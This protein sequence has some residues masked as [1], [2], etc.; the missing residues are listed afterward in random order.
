MKYKEIDLTVTDDHRNLKQSIYKFSMEV[1]R[2]A[3]IELD[4]MTPGQVISKGSPFWQGMEKMYEHS[5]HA[6]VLPE[7]MGGAGLGPL[8]Q[9]IFWEGLGYG[10]AGFAIALGVGVFA[11]LAVAM[12]GGGESQIKEFVEPFLNCKDASVLSCWAITE[13]NHGSDNLAVGTDHFRSPKISQQVRAVKK[14]NKYIVSGQKSAWVS[15]GPVAT[16]AV[17]F[18]GIDSSKGMAGGGVCIIDLTQ[19]GVSKGVPLNK[20]GQRELPQGEIFFDN[21]EVP[22]E[23]MIV[24][25][26]GYENVL[27]AVLAHANSCI[28]APVFVGVAQSAYDLA[29]Q[30]CSERKV[31][32]KLLC[33]HQLTKKRLFDMFM[34]IELARAFSRRVMHYN[35]TSGTPD[36]KYAIASKVHCTNTAFEVA[37]EAV[38]LFGGYGLSKE[39]PI[40][41]IFRDARASLIED[42]TNESLSLVGG[43]IIAQEL[44]N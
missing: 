4:S 35:M 3:A 18:L 5:Y 16:N 22:E 36:L 1:L 21:A 25:P 34:R 17:L 40:E 19:S 29:L 27:R 24:L 30:Y 23:N 32:G 12:L 41:K 28:M 9:H 8:N 20:I 44:M 14:G 33:E 15:C 6:V 39:Y 31:G 13:P 11:P 10:S 2:P 43:N 37:N 42:G 26:E 38:Q 7:A